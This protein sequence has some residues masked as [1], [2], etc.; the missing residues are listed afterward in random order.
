M[1]RLFNLSY[2]RGDLHLFYMSVKIKSIKQ[3]VWIV[4]VYHRSIGILGC[5]L[6]FP[7]LVVGPWVRGLLFVVVETRGSRVLDEEAWVSGYFYMNRNMCTWVSIY[8]YRGPGLSGLG[9]FLGI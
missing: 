4:E 9:G 5:D 7:R 3:G 8:R 1:F 2:L 6:R